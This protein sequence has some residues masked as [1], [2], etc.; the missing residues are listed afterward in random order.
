MLVKDRTQLNNI[1]FSDDIQKTKAY[2]KLW[3]EEYCLV[4]W[5]NHLHHK[6]IN[7][8]AL[9]WALA[10]EALVSDR[11]CDFPDPWISEIQDLICNHTQFE[12]YRSIMTREEY[13]SLNSLPEKV[14][15][16]RGHTEEYVRNG[17]SWTLE[18]EIAEYFATFHQRYETKTTVLQGGIQRKSIIALLLR[19]N[20]FEVFTPSQMVKHKTQ[21][22]WNE[23]GRNGPFVK[24]P[25]VMQPIHQI[26]NAVTA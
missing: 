6:N 16:F 11:N 24:F 1:K 19:K 20:E 21:I 25:K 26:Q 18:K 17:F 8:N 7:N 22:E 15:V 12:D 13:L 10:G 3:S 14:T 23:L 9:K 5:I 4:D 2:R